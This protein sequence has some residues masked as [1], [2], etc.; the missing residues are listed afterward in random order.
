MVR[1]LKVRS[2]SSVLA[3]IVLLAGGLGLSGCES[4]SQS[5]GGKELLDYRRATL[6]SS[7]GE[8]TPEQEAQFMMMTLTARNYADVDA[9]LE[10]L[11]VQ[12]R[13]RDEAL[14]RAEREGVAVGDRRRL[15]RRVYVRDPETG[16][17]KLETLPF[18]SE[19]SPGTFDPGTTIFG[20]QEDR[21]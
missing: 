14:V 5:R 17:Y 13:V 10:T 11:K 19:N 1:L 9:A 21:E 18:D 20:T 8:L 15:I 12:T 7:A 2:C 4:G 16:N 6:D 3:I